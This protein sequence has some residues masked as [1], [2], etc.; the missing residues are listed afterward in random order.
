MLWRKG[1]SL[2]GIYNLISW[3]EINIIADA[4]NDKLVRRKQAEDRLNEIEP[5]MEKDLAL[6]KRLDRYVFWGFILFKVVIVS[7]FFGLCILSKYLLK[8]SWADLYEFKDK[9]AWFSGI[10]FFIL[11]RSEVKYI[12]AYPWMRAIVRNWVYRKYGHLEKKIEERAVE[13]L[14]LK[15]EIIQLSEPEKTLIANQN[16]PNLN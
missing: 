13:I 6:K 7:I 10:A 11:F 12:R 5:E 1:I 8:I 2:S 14:K 3:G 16:N 4:E 15:E 9:A